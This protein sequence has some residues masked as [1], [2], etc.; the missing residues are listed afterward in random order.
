[1]A[2][3]SASIVDTAHHH[4]PAIVSQPYLQRRPGVAVRAR[5]RRRAGFVTQ[6]RRRAAAGADAA[7]HAFAQR[8]DCSRHGRRRSAAS[9]G[10]L[11]TVIRCAMTRW[12]LVATA[13][14]LAFGS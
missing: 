2:A 3:A 11:A 6:G 5:E 12:V 10:W 9:D 4:R 13:F 8:S 14:V 1:M 7:R